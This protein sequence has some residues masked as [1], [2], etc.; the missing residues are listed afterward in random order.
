MKKYLIFALLFINVA[1]APLRA[2][3]GLNYTQGSDDFRQHSLALDMSLSRRMNL[4]LDYSVSRSNSSPADTKVYSGFFDLRMNDFVSLGL[5]VS[6]SPETEDSRSSGWGISGSLNRGESPFE[7][8]VAL[9]YNRTTFSEHATYL[10][11]QANRR[12]WNSR[13][14]WL[15]LG[16]QEISPSLFCTLY[17]LF[18]ARAGVHYYSYDKA[19]DSFSGEL[20][21][22]S[23]R[24]VI[25][26]DM[27]SLLDEFP[28]RIVSS[29][30]SV[31]PLEKL[32]FSLDWSR[33]FFVLDNPN[34]DS[35]TYA[36]SYRLM[37][38]L[39]V[40]GSYNRVA[41]RDGYYSLGM[42]FSW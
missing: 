22:L 5:E 28:E 24:T 41:Y 21:R 6:L 23:K 17:G 16:R 32:I 40:K 14:E 8:G 4:F 7:W 34:E 20:S 27:L 18:H 2:D 35:L 12:R 36:L 13:D 10:T 26:T 30:V 42:S 38:H 39:T 37:N 31:V 11:Y 33:T 19:L 1:A 15:D 29:G 3:V 9:G 25:T